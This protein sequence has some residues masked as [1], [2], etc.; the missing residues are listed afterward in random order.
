MLLRHS[1]V[2]MSPGWMAELVWCQDLDR[3]R[4][5]DLSR[6]VVVMVENGALERL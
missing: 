3:S 5:R 6:G 1:R 2:R 4:D